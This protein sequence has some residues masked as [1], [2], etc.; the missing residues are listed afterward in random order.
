MNLIP[1]K[2][3]CL[4]RRISSKRISNE[5]LQEK[6]A[7]QKPGQYKKQKSKVIHFKRSSSKQILH[8]KKIDNI[9]KNELYK[10]HEVCEVSPINPRLSRKISKK[11]LV[12]SDLDFLI[13]STISSTL[14]LSGEHDVIKTMESV[15]DLPPNDISIDSQN[16]QFDF[17]D[18]QQEGNI[19]DRMQN[20]LQD[21]G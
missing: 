2:K 8:E 17:W 7:L 14:P 13:N 10:K 3:G 16:L 18:S 1:L 20:L 5:S 21:Y 19:T 12:L 9:Q 11:D 15:P 4:H 6:V